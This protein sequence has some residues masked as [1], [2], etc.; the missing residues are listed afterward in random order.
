M[1]LSPRLICACSLDICYLLFAHVS[2]T[3]NSS[4]D[5][6]CTWALL[7]LTTMFLNLKSDCDCVLTR[8]A[9][10]RGNKCSVV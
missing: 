4:Y 7:A 3:G 8:K 2:M 5:D 10:S 9:T 6:A 1:A